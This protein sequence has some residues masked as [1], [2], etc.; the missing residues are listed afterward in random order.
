M[1]QTCVFLS[2]KVSLMLE[3]KQD[4]ASVF[5]CDDYDLFKSWQS[6]KDLLLLLLL[7]LLLTTSY[8]SEGAQ[9]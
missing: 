1:P 8:Y 2:P 4:N 5:A 6:A 7:L 9:R 3:A